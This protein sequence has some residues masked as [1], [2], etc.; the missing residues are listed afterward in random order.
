VEKRVKVELENEMV[1]QLSDAALRRFYSSIRDGYT[2]EQAMQEIV[3]TILRAYAEA[4]A[5]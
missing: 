4:V 5:S 1:K 2:E 3:R